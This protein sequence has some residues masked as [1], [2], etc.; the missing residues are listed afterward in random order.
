MSLKTKLVLGSLANVIVFGA[1]DMLTGRLDRG[2]KKFA[3]IVLVAVGA[4]ILEETIG[5]AIPALDG[6]IF[7]SVSRAY[8]FIALFDGVFTMLQAND[9]I[10]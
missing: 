7:W 10:L 6:W 8:V 5:G 1:A 2:L 9:I 4:T 3:F